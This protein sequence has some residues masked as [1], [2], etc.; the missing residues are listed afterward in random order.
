MASLVSLALTL[1]LALNSRE[2]T[3]FLD[4]SSPSR[5]SKINQFVPYLVMALRFICGGGF[6]GGLPVINCHA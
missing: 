5:I 2:N 4:L 1:T 3:A 6:E